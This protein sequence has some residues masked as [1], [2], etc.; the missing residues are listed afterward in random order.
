MSAAFFG[1]FLLNKGLIDAQQLAKALTAQEV[2]NKKL[3]EL[4]LA[5]NLLSEKQVREILTLQKKKTC[6]LVKERK[7]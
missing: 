1:Q 2:L 6:F 5:K 3:G 4:A 7:S